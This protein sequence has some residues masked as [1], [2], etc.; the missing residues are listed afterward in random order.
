MEVVLAI[1][2][3]AVV[4]FSIEWVIRFVR[5]LQD[6]LFNSLSGKDHGNV[7]N[8][9][10]SDQSEE[11][12]LGL[13][14]PLTS[15]REPSTELPIPNDSFIQEVSEQS[16]TSQFNIKNA[17]N[18]KAIELAK[19]YEDDLKL[20]DKLSQFALDSGFD[21]ALI[22]VWGD[23]KWRREVGARIPRIDYILCKAVATDNEE[24]VEIKN[25]ES[26]YLFCRKN[27]HIQKTATHF[28]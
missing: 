21:K 19:K 14:H 28:L 1:L 23:I 26:S 4:I 3:G 8:Q 6:P 12:G 11:A 20:K 25:D 10:P 22:A 9:G 17:K 24:I 5:R 16:A 7:V 18:N 27:L 13:A 2:L 15:L